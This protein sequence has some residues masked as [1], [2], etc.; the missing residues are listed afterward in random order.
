MTAALRTCLRYRGQ[1]RGGSRAQGGR[2]LHARRGGCKLGAGPLSRSVPGRRP[3]RRGGLGPGRGEGAGDPG[4]GKTSEGG[5][6]ASVRLRAAAGAGQARGSAPR[7]EPGVLPGARGGGARG[8]RERRRR[9]C[10]RRRRWRKK[11]GSPAKRPFQCIV[12]TF[13]KTLCIRAAPAENFPCRPSAPDPP[14]S[15][16]GRVWNVGRG[17]PASSRAAF[18]DP[19]FPPS[20]PTLCLLVSMRPKSLTPPPTCPKARRLK[21]SLNDTSKSVLQNGRDL[22]SK[23]RVVSTRLLPNPFIVEDPAPPLRD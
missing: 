16:D 8:R 5:G 9:R 6:S 23:G 13:R 15:G 11:T 4:F 17:T 21:T 19:V 18:Y 7:V 2:R 3:S 1:A 22:E 10:R 12:R 20:A 14:N